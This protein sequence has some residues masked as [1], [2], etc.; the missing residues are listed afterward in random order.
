VIQQDNR[1]IY[2]GSFFTLTHERATLPNGYVHEMEII[3]HPGACAILAVDD[4]ERLCLIRQWRHAAGGW[5]WEVPAGKLEA[6]EPPLL[7]AQR[8]LAEEAGIEAAHWQSLGSLLPSPGF[9]DERIHLFLAKGLVAVPT[10]R[11][12]AEVM[13]VHQLSWPQVQAMANGDIT[14][15]KTL[16]I[17]LRYALSQK[18]S[19]S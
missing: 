2:K 3:H 9:C 18:I 12:P 17:L 4:A 8:E 14:D 19:L 6:G 1:L 10:A 7:A 11:E 16:S 5:L 13:E 15:A